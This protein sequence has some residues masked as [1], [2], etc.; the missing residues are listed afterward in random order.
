MQLLLLP[1][2]DGTGQLFEPLIAALPPTLRAVSVS[3]PVN[4]ALGYEELLALIEAAV[5]PGRFV[6]VGESF[7]GPLAGR[8]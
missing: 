4:D 2:M 8:G 7:S 3:Y 5:P 1:G 6:A